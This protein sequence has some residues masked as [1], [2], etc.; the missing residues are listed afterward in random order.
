MKNKKYFFMVSIFVLFGS[1]TF[2][3]SAFLISNFYL[4]GL[5][6]SYEM[7][8]KQ[9]SEITNNISI[10]IMRSL[11]SIAGQLNVLSRI[12]DNTNIIE[13][14]NII[15]KVM[16]EQLKSNENIA[17][18]FLADEY[19]NFLQSRREPELAFRSIN[20]IDKRNL[21]TWYFKN[22]NYLT[23]S[24][25][26]YKSKY[27][28]RTRE[29]YKAVENSK[30][31]WS[32]PY[33]FDSTKEPGIT[34]SIG[35]FN[36]YNQKI[37]VA[38]ANFTLN[39]ISKLLESKASIL[40]GKLILFN[41]S[42]NII[43]TSFNLDLK[44]K[45]NKLLKFEDLDSNL[46]SDTFKK[47]EK[48][49]FTGELK[50]KNGKNYI[51]YVSKLEKNSGQ[52]WYIASYVEKDFITADIKNTLVNSVLISLLIIIIYFPIQYI[53]QKFVTK[54]INELE[55]LTNEIAN[56]RYENIKP[57]KTN[58]YEFHNLS[59]SMINMSKAI[60]E[61]EKGQINLIDSFIKILAEAIDSKSIVQVV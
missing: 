13:N 28:A 34:I 29:W 48:N 42:K 57:V 7:L 39:K 30:I 33:I 46:Y 50:D 49:L 56:N 59:T 18:I 22:T 44:T 21:E 10:T 17:S 61:Y 38:A 2:L 54:P 25:Q 20:Y 47:I 52:N 4:R 23:T 1:L 6:Q 27:D 43:A 5:N 12:T 15:E 40:N 19:G 51:Y 36:Q 9:N 37:K 45:D 32:E 16:W 55:K 24:I 41:Q 31:F 11:E 35:D 60:Q 58:I 53:L 26:I 14:Q 3:L 8:E